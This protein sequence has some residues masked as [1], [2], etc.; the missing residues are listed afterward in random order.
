MQ[1]AAHTPGGYGGVPQN[2]G[3][4]FVGDSSKRIQAAG[5]AFMA[6]GKVLLMKR[7]DGGDYAGHWAFPG[8]HIEPEEGAEEAA[9]REV[10]EEAGYSTTGAIRNIAFTDNGYCQFTLFGKNCQ[11]FAPVL[12]DE[13]TEFIWAAPDEYPEPL[14]PGTKLILDGNALDQIDVSKMTELDIARMIASCELTSPQRWANM[15]LFALRITGTGTAYRSAHDEYVY[16]PPELYLNDE[17]LQRCNGLQVIW[18]HPPEDRLDSEE[19]RKR[20]IGAILLPYIQGDEVWGVA[21]IYDDVAIQIMSDP[22]RPLSTSPT[23]VFRET[24]GNSEVTLDTGEK[25]LIEGRPFLLDHLA[26]CEYGVWDK[27]G[28]P[29]GVL[30]STSEALK[31]TEEEKKAEEKAKAD[32]ELA[33][34]KAK[35]D[36]YDGLMKAKADAEEEAKKKAEEE[37]ETKAKKV[38][39]DSEE[40]K[41][42]A[43]AARIDKAIAD[44]VAAGLKAIEARLPKARSDADFAA[45]ASAQARADSVAHAFGKSA[46]RPLDGEDLTGYRQRLLSDFQS[47][48]PSWKGA[49]L[50]DISDSAVLDI[51]E[52][53]IYADAMI[54]ANTPGAPS[55]GGLREVK[56]RS[57]AGH[58]IS[59][60]YGDPSAW[61]SKFKM[62]TRRVTHINKGA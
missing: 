21:K 54:A 30:N 60:F 8:G 10:L 25:L 58:S 41:A 40:E 45:M 43:D 34:L 17:F 37:E 51:A 49:K 3:K 15:S 38:A 48:S 44:G 26:V 11:E 42:K 13:N 62:P 16:R 6:G 35:A 57:D 32:A 20:T 29:K 27:G 18:V 53:Q 1:A 56:N 36:A 7:G 61:M 39:A 28:N 33:E 55:G 14:H 24:D 46:P 23:V 5:I 9:R 22:E 47:H 50:T 12:N 31:M 52:K 4:E 19:F 2:V 59:M